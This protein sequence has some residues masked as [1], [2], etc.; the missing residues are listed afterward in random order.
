MQRTVVL[1]RHAKSSW[2][3][4]SEK[5]FD[6]ALNERGKKDAPLMGDELKKRNIIPDAIISSTARRARQT[7]KRIA[8]AVGFDIEQIQQIDS[9]YLCEPSAFKDVITNLEITVNT[10]FIIAH[11]PGITEFANQLSNQ[12]RVDDM[13]TCAVVVAQASFQSWLEF[14]EGT[15]DVILFEY[16]KQFYDSN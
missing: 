14:N 1:I 4:P 16:P 11:N 2:A 12:F 5:D 9:L 8:K 15:M 10:V 7:A 6:R 13:P 3:N